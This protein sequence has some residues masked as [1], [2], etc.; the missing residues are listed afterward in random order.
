MPSKRSYSKN[1][2]KPCRK[3]KALMKGGSGSS[4][5]VQAVAGGIGQQH[6][7]SGTNVMAMNAQA[8]TAMRG[9]SGDAA[10]NAVPM[11]GISPATVG[12]AK[13]GKKGGSSLTS[14]AVP[15][16][17]LVANQMMTKRRRSSHKKRRSFRR[18]R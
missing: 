18:R 8:A 15:A 2:R 5:Y 17:L 6:A 14:L 3:G 16:V 11:V 7:V 4:E 13:R 1:N 9:G 10:P 12:G